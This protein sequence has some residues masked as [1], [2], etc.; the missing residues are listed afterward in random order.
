MINVANCFWPPQVGLSCDS[1]TVLHLCN[2]ALTNV[3]LN[4]NMTIDH[5]M[6]NIRIIFVYCFRKI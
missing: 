4:K 6:N 5:Q 3:G 1:A 2:A